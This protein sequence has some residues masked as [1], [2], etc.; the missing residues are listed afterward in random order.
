MKS[1]ERCITKR[2]LKGER[3][4]SR[5]DWDFASELRE[6]FLNGVSTKDLSK[7][8]LAESEAD[9]MGLYWALLDMGVYT[10]IYIHFG[11][12]VKYL[13]VG[14]NPNERDKYVITVDW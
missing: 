5:R 7:K 4:Y 1:F 9:L 6:L 8:E 10:S 14:D 2:A 3:L 12:G 13:L 11:N